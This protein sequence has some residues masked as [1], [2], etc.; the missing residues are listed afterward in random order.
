MK[1]SRIFCRGICKI[2]E[3]EHRKCVKCGLYLCGI[4]EVIYHRKVYCIDCFLKDL[5]IVTDIKNEYED[6]LKQIEEIKEEKRKEKLKK[7]F[8]VLYKNEA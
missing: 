3:R 7:E 1:N 5:D 8:P 6:I 4:C 2:W